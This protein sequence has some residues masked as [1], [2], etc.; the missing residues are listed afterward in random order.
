[1]LVARAL[2]AGPGA[3]SKVQKALQHSDVRGALCDRLSQVARGIREFLVLELDQSQ[4][5]KSVSVIGSEGQRSSEV[6]F[7]CRLIAS[8]QGIDPEVIQHRDRIGPQLQ[9]VQEG[10][11]SLP[12]FTVLG[13]T[14]ALRKVC[15]GQVLRCEGRQRDRKKSGE[16][17]GYQKNLRANWICRETRA[18]VTGTPA[19]E[20][21]PKDCEPTEEFGRLNCGVLKAL[22]SSVRNWM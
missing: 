18:K 13:V 1:M 15:L 22:K 19:P 12:V 4:V 5:E 14:D 17:H 16:C 9:G 20:I 7:G 2:P 21:W 3:C 11:V 6:P 8:M 10:D